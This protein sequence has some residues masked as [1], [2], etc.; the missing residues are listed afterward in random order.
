M[1]DIDMT[2]HRADLDAPVFQR[3][4]IQ[5]HNIVDV[6]QQRRARQPHVE[7]GNQALPAGQET[8]FAVVL[9]EQLNRVFD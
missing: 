7:R 6:D 3:D 8:R 5:P 2:R 4:T 9:A 1:L